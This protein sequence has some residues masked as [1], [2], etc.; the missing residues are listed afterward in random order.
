M[1]V[2]F[3]IATIATDNLGTASITRGLATNRVLEIRPANASEIAA[4][5]TAV[6]ALV[7]Y[8]V[9]GNSQRPN[10]FLS[11]T[12]VATVKTAVNA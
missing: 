3:D 6:T 11:A 9:S 8:G 7:Y 2:T 4:F 1:A 10:T 12:A 5:P